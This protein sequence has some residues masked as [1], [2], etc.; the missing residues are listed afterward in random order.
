MESI[1]EEVWQES[2]RIFP[3]RTINGKLGWGWLMIRRRGGA[4]EFRYRTNDEVE[5]TI[6]KFGW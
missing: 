1:D 3:V 2:Y 4:M 5:A 6:S